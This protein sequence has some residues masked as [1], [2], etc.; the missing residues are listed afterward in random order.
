MA[1]NIHHSD[2]A[3]IVDCGSEPDG[4]RNVSGA[5]FESS[6]RGL[7]GGFFEC[8]VLNHVAAALPGLRVFENVVLAKNDADAG[9]G[10]DFVAGED[11]EIAIIGLHVYMHVRNSLSPVEK[12]FGAVPVGEFDDVVNR[13]NGAERV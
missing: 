2:A 7:V 1:R 12:N 6:W 8:H 4:I 3:E 13:R 5:S 11:V 9:R 10:E